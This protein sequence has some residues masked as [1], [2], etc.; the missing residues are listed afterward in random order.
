MGPLVTHSSR[1]TEP[2]A[3]PHL[4]SCDN[5]NWVLPG[6][7]G[8]AAAAAAGFV[9]IRKH[10][11]RQ[12]L[13]LCSH[14]CPLAVTPSSWQS[15]ARDLFMASHKSHCGSSLFPTLCTLRSPLLPAQSP[16]CCLCV[17]P[18]S[19]F[20]DVSAKADV[21]AG[22]PQSPVP[23]LLEGTVL[24]DT[25]FPSIIQNPKPEDEVGAPKHHLSCPN[26]LTHS[27]TALFPAPGFLSHSCSVFPGQ[28]QPLALCLSYL[29]P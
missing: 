25:L 9:T 10:F 3:P 14:T 20:P 28:S 27:C 21:S 18:T 15:P 1:D 23:P 4:F 17:L 6:Q 8:D 7:E 12:L 22:Q 11:G 26:K 24:S 29:P 16:C 2:R 19:S 5:A 13:P